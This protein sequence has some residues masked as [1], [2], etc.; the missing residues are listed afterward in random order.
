MRAAAIILTIASLTL[1][2]GA[3]GAQPC[4]FEAG[5]GQGEYA[6]RRDG[7]VRDAGGGA[8]IQRSWDERLYGSKAWFGK[9]EHTDCDTG[10][11]TTAWWRMQQGDQENGRFF[12]NFEAG[13]EFWGKLEDRQFQITRLEFYD[14]A[15]SNNLFVEL[16]RVAAETCGCN[17][18]YPELVGDKSS[19][20]ASQ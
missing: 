2:A 8:V 3:I 12:S 5:S 20:E 17:A 9:V 11:R 4:V 19:Y 6:E 1:P 14:L 7:V 18:I 15:G 13:N 10:L 16:D